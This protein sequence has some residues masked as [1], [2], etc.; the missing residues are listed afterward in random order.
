VEPDKWVITLGQNLLGGESGNARVRP[1][2]WT[3][4]ERLQNLQRQ[5]LMEDVI[6]RQQ[7]E[8]DTL[9]GRQETHF[10]Q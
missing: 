1:V 5:D 7:A 8:G 9:A 2:K 4:V 10:S 3:R 6:K